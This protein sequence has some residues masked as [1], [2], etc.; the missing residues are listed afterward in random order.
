M[1]MGLVLV[2]LPGCVTSTATD[3]TLSAS[4]VPLKAD[5][6]AKPSDDL[7]VAINDFGLDLVKAIAT[8]PGT[9]AIVSPASVH[10][11]L[12]MTANG[13]DGETAEQMRHVLHVGEMTAAE[14]NDGWASLLGGLGDRS[15]EQTLEIANSLWARKGIA[16]KTPFIDADRDY[17]GAQVSTLDFTKDDVPG[18]INGWVSKNT[19]GMIT[20]MIDQ[21]PANAILYLANAV[22][23][24]GEWVSG[25]AHE[26][27]YKQS[28]T[29]QD[30]STVDVDIMHESGS[31]P[32]AENATVQATKL[33]YKGGDTA[34]YVLLPKPGVKIG[35][36]L[37]GLKGAGFRDLR[38][39]MASDEPTKVILGL[40]KLDVEFSADLSK[41]LAD[42]G[43]PRAFDDR[44]AQFSSMA[45]LD[46]PIYIGRV[47]HKTK[48]KV[49]EKG[50]EAAAATVVE[51]DA[52][53]APEP[54]EMKRII[55]DRPYVFAIVDETSGAM[56]FLGVVND[57]RK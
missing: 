35:A 43:M 12:S 23:F 39:A 19:H 13:A 51:M 14:A 31:M 9:S 40:P 30:G 56:L 7:S 22:Y 27:T 46:V 10:A 54:V 44:R 1:V 17:F 55:C 16:F 4:G 2:A 25:F 53:A 38:R 32:Y 33:P 57:P 11:A 36:A 48:V 47:L 37:D 24:K 18:A 42:L 3:A 20:R 15:S 26:S 52:G 5:S 50:T 41:Q 34:F 28:F 21:T 29:K 45:D 6:K 49:D 8:D